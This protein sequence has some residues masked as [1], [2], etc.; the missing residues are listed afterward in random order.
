M[1][2]DWIVM[3]CSFLFWL[4]CETKLG[5]TITWLAPKSFLATKYA[6]LSAKD[7]HTFGCNAGSLI[8]AIVVSQGAARAFL[9]FPHSTTDAYFGRYDLAAFYLCIAAGYFVWDIKSVIQDG[10]GPAFLFQ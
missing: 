2:Y 4:F 9:T 5:D 7:K 3:M 10:Q 1:Q 8:H 6:K